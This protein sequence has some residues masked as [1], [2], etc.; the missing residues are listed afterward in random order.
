MSGGHGFGGSNPPS[1]KKGRSPI[2]GLPFSYLGNPRVFLKKNT[3]V[4]RRPSGRKTKGRSKPSP[5]R[6]KHAE[7]CAF[8]M[9]F[10][11]ADLNFSRA[12]AQ[13]LRSPLTRYN[14]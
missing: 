11:E 5:I 4:Q 12:V 7:G 3:R 9:C 10:E 6:K 2:G 14:K 8:F 1:P 13:Q